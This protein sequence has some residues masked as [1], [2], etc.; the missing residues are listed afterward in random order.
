MIVF[1]ISNRITD[2]VDDFAFQP[3][4]PITVSSSGHRRFQ[5]PADEDN[6]Y[7]RTGTSSYAYHLQNFFKLWLSSCGTSH[8]LNYDYLKLCFTPTNDANNQVMVAHWTNKAIQKGVE[9]LEL[10]FDRGLDPLRYWYSKMSWIIWCF[11][12]D[13]SENDSLE[14]NTR[15]SEKSCPIPKREI[16]LSEILLPQGS[17]LTRVAGVE[18]SPEDVGHALHFLEFCKAF[19]ESFDPKKGHDEQV[20]RD[21]AMGRQG[22]RSQSSVV[23]QI[24]IQLL[25]LIQDDGDEWCP[26]LSPTDGQNSWL[27]ALRDLVSKSP[28]TSKDFPLECFTKGNIGYEEPSITERL[29]LLI[30]LCDKVLL[31]VGTTLSNNNNHH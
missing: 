11:S 3:S 21:L 15:P 23:I 6:S 1:L 13:S 5:V 19:G 10:N 20:I 2:T 12:D 24:H 17:G 29:K 27:Q 8:L 26:T 22:C 25:S 28:S 14:T 18:L 31:V 9:E 7:Q 4:Q 16:V 30:F